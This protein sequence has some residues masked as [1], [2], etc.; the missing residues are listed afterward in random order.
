[1]RA[2]QRRTKAADALIASTYLAGTYTRRVLRAFA[3][4]FGG[5]VGKDKVSRVWRKVKT[6]SE[7]WNAQLAGPRADRAIDPRRD[8]RARP[9]RPQGNFGL[10]LGDRGARGRGQGH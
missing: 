9:A 8:V 10:A 7:T 6:D 2:R 4:L 1:L 5:A 3:A